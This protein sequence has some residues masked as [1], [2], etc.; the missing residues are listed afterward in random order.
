MLWD[1]EDFK[2][3]S[4][5]AAS[6]LGSLELS[7]CTFDNKEWKY[8]EGGAGETVLFLHGIG[9]TKVLWRPLMHALSGRYRIIAP[10]IPGLNINLDI[11]GKLLAKNSI[12]SW[13]N[14]FC[15]ELQLD[16]VNL[17][18]QGSG[19][20]LATYFAHANP[21]R[22]EKLVWFSPPD[23]DRLRFGLIPEWEGLLLGF[24]TVDEISRY[25][26]RLFYRPP[27]YPNVVKYYLLKKT[28][29][30]AKEG[31]VA[32]TIKREIEALPMLRSKLRSLQQ[33]T[34]FVSGDH[35]F[36]GSSNWPKVISQMAPNGQFAIIDRCGHYCFIEKNEESVDIISEFLDK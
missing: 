7:S 9:N 29:K 15:D 28:Q 31:K 1:N 25:L 24:K 27:R 22:I 23:F 36:M 10:D 3:L 4:N 2:R 11:S 20:A 19:G 14:S 13:L 6:Y 33:Q 17:V 21:A 26:D 34:L 5:V 12:V 30:V 16:K 32:R 35:D 8:L 18:G